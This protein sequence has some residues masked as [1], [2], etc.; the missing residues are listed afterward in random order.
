[1]SVQTGEAAGQLL[2]ALTAAH[3]MYE[4]PDNT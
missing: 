4:V 2:S 3:S 1:M